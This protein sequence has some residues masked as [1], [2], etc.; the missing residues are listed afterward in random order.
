VNGVFENEPAA[1][2]GLKPATSS[3]GDGRRGDASALPV[4]WRAGPGHKVEL[5][6]SGTAI[7]APE[8]DLG[9]RKEE[10]IVASIPPRLLSRRSGSA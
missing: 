1:R 4:A 5:R 9:E 10:D 2:A 3:R 8:V 6:S 7:A